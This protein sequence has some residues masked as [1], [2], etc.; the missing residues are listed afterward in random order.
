MKNLTHLFSAT[1]PALT[2]TKYT[3]LLTYI[4]CSLL[5]NISHAH[6]VQGGGLINGMMH[7]VF[8]TDHLLAMVAVGALSTQIGGKAIW[9]IPMSFVALML[10]GGVWGMMKMP[11]PVVETGIA[12]SVLV[13]GVAIAFDKKMPT[14]WSMVCVG[15]FALFHGYAHGMEMPYLAQPALYTVG[16]ILATAFLHVMGIVIGEIAK[17]IKSG[18]SLLRYTGAG[19]AGIGFAILTGI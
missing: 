6:G 12:L 2:L 3:L 4:A 14:I 9:T 17:R 11:F 8:G 7:P 15:F 16:F 5:T 18:D 19:V 13:L 10:C 1:H